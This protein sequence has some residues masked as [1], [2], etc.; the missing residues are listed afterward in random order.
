MEE[1]Y[2]GRDPQDL[3]RAKMKLMLDHGI[4]PA[5][6]LGGCLMLLL[7]MPIFM[8]LY[9]SLQENVFFRLKPFLWIHNLAAPDMLIGWSDKIP[10]ISDVSNMGGSFWSFLYLG[11]YFNIMPIIAVALML[12]QQKL[13][14]PP[15]A[16]AQQAQQQKM[17]K[18]MLIV[19]AVV[20]YKTPSGLV[21]YFIISTLWGL[22]ERKLFPKKL[23]DTS[24]SGGK[25]GD[26]AKLKPPPP[27]PG[28]LRQQFQ[29]VLDA[30]EKKSRTERR[31]PKASR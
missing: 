15:A 7:Q 12:V 5:A 8:G 29:T 6:Q 27:K 19:F 21:L 24:A 3:H 2:R 20:F 14:T 23:A 26:G 11:P 4:N 10:I 31:S 22:A 17:M 9:Y 1:E 18:W 28:W 13:M 16:D 30:A 25:G